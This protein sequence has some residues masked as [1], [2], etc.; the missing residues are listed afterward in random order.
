MTAIT[1]ATKTRFDYHEKLRE[2]VARWSVICAAAT[3]AGVDP[4]TIE[5]GHSIKTAAAELAQRGDTPERQ[6]LE[7]TF[8]AELERLP[9]RGWD[10]D[11]AARVAGFA[12]KPPPSPSAGLSDWHAWALAQLKPGAAS[13]S[14]VPET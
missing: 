12:G 14:A 2:R 13:P 3:A 4:E 9:R 5:R 11:L 8:L 7:A 10:G 6:R 1:E